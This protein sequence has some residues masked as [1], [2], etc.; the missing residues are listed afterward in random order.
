MRKSSIA[1]IT[2]TC[3]TIITIGWQLGIQGLPPNGIESSNSDPTATSQASVT[4]PPEAVPQP[5]FA[6]PQ[7]PVAAPAP[8]P[9]TKH[10]KEGEHDDDENSAH[11]PSP[12]AVP[13][14]APASPVQVVPAPAAPKNETVAGTSSSTRYG[15]V[16]VSVTFNG[17]TITDVTALKLTNADSRSVSISNRAA[18]IL[19]SSVLK[20]QSAKVST[21]S[22]ATYT[23]EGYLA[24]VQSAIDKHNGK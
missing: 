6:E 10:E 24:S 1:G 12:A 22:G 9:V 13:T 17:N 8:E 16:Q 21:V 4:T 5:T 18:P 2:L 23:S 11:A 19:K 15:S 7:T 14:T 3:G 20:S